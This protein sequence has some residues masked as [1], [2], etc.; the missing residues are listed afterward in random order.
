M[1]ALPV[2]IRPLA[3][4]LLTAPQP[5]TAATD[6]DLLLLL[7]LQIL[8]SDRILR[9]RLQPQLPQPLLVLRDLVEQVIKV[10]SQRLSHDPA[11]A[12]QS[13]VDRLPGRPSPP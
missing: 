13:P 5:V 6:R 8:V 1:Y 9:P 3:S 7:V 10:L 11:V 2:K 12:R 4:A